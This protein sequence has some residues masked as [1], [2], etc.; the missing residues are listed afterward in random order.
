MR[1]SGLTDDVAVIRS[2]FGD[3]L[4]GLGYASITLEQ[5][6]RKLICVATWLR[7]HPCHPSL[8]E[9]TRRTVPGMLAKMLP[10]RS[11]E[12]RNYYRKALFHWLR[13][14][15]RYS[16]P[17]RQCWGP[18][19]SDYLQFLRTHQGVSRSTLD[20]NEANAKAFLTWQFGTGRANWS[21]VK[22]TDIWRFAHHYVQGVKSTTAKSRLGYVRRFL[23]FVHLRGAC[24]PELA[25]S[26]P[27]VAVSRPPPR[28]AVLSEQQ[29]SKLLGSFSR[30]SPEGKR[31]YAMTL[32]MLDLG[33]RCG[34]VIGL[35]LDDI[36]WQ[37]GWLNIRVTKTGRGR[38]LPL[39]D[40][41]LG[42]MSKY[43]KT[44]RP[45]N[46]PSDHF[47]VRLSRRSGYP[48]TRN[49]L[50]AIVRC[51]YRHCGFPPNWSGTHRLRHTFASRLHHRGVDMKP[52]ADML[53]HRRLDST[54][55]YTQL[56]MEA[57]RHVAQPWP[58]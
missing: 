14:Q 31:N 51:A 48:L 32:C 24:G 43:L 19:I 57:L 17:I 35:R 30:T 37:R 23:R 28:P 34:E 21:R 8:D 33:L 12:T 13:F 11:A 53:G 6:Q 36:D 15:G 2:N 18:W 42:A 39:P 41:I 44:A 1:R 54:N 7:E 10:R 26:I 40:H 16:E 55:L 52:I 5:Y 45:Q 56:D 49:A 47:F 25:A 22:P 50:K 29:R 9:F 27:K 46:A 38:Q 3:Y 58:R 20:L 4:R